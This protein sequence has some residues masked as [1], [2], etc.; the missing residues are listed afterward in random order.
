[1][2]LDTATL[3]APRRSRRPRLRTSVFGLLLTLVAVSVI[4]SE[5][6]GDTLDGATIA[7][8]ALIGSGAILL[9]GAVGASMRQES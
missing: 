8:A 3:D 4:V 9:V 7:I 5:W 6:T 2:N 1:V